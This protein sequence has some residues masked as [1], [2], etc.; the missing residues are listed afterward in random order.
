MAR[1]IPCDE[2]GCEYADPRDAKAIEVTR[3]GG[4]AADQPDHGRDR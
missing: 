4:F 1:T 2:E 3:C